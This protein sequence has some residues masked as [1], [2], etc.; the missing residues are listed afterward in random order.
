MKIIKFLLTIVFLFVASNAE[1]QFW[2]KLKKKAGKAAE[3]AVIRKVEEK[4]AEKTEQTM[5]TIFETPKKVGKKRRGN[6]TDESDNG[7]YDSEEEYEETPSEE[8]SQ[9]DDSGSDE[10]SIFR[11][12]DFVPG[13]DILLYDD[14][15]ADGVGDFPSKW[16]TNGSG[17]LVEVNG[18]KWIKFS[19]KSIYMPLLEGP[20]PKEFTIEFDVLL[21]N[22]P[23]NEGGVGSSFW[24]WVDENPAYEAGANWAGASVGLW[25]AIK[26]QIRIKNTVQRKNL[27]NTVIEYKIHDK[28]NDVAHVSVAVNKRRFRL[29]VNEQKLVDSPRLIP[30]VELANIKWQMVSYP[31]D[32]LISNIKIAAGGEDLRSKLMSEGRFTTTGIL[33]D[34]GSASIQPS[35]YGV[36]KKIASALKESNI[37]VKIVG[38]TD[39]DGSSEANLTLSKDRAEA[40]KTALTSEFGVD[41]SLLSTEGMGELEPIADNRTPEGKAQNRRAEFI[42]Q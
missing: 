33:F 36:L 30:D 13:E 31:D 1:A 19:E 11:K 12:F 14:F 9:Y 8:D 20:L 3:E 15:S 5:D 10:L 26:N 38:H 21:I 16:D 17:E 23:E 24:V 37:Q 27:I 42:K 4:T 2:K 29:W 22:F 34:S 39:S 6:R 32:F 18:K 25:T 35:S 28:F 7:E 41:G 40:I